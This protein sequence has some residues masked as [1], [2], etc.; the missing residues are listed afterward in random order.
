MGQGKM[1]PDKT[2]TIRLINK[3]L[4]E[5]LKKISK[6]TGIAI[7][8]HNTELTPYSKVSLEVENQPFLDVL[9]TLLDKRGFTWIPVNESAI[10]IKRSETTTRIIN[11]S[12]IDTTN[13]F[14]VYGKVTNQKGEPIP[15]AT[16]LIRGKNRGVTTASNGS[17]QINDIGPNTLLLISNIAFVSQEIRV[18]EKGNLGVISLLEYVGKLDET[19]VVA[20]GT[21]TKRMNLGNI[22]SVKEKEIS[23]SPIDNPLL[24]LQ[25]R[26]A[27]VF[28]EQST[29]LAGSGITVRVQGQNSL[30]RGN[31]PLYVID[32]IPYSSQLLPSLNSILG[33]NGNTSPVTMGSGSPLSFINPNDIESIDV[34]KDADATSIYGSRAA[35][36]AIL[37]T[38]KKGRAGETKVNLSLQQGIGMVSRYSD[39]LN[40]EEYLQMRREALKN[41]NATIQPTDYDLD[42]T[43]D[44]LRYTDWQ[45][46]LIGNLAKYQDLQ[47][48]ISGGNTQ[49]Q[50]LIGGGYRRQTTVFP[51]DFDDKKLSFHLN[52]SSVSRN[53]KL[54]V[55]VTASYMNDRNSL[56]NSDFT[57]SAL[58]LAPN[59]PSLYNSDGAVN[60][61][62]NQNNE[63]TF[64]ENPIPNLSLQKYKITSNNLISNLQTSYS[65]IKGLDIK[66]SVGYNSFISDE[67]RTTP[68]ISN[69]PEYLYIGSRLRRASYGDNQTRSW[70][71]EPQITY[72]KRVK[73]HK[74]DGVIGL[75]FNESVSNGVQISG[76][77]YNSDEI[78]QDVKSAAT[79]SVIS[80]S[81][82]NYKYSAGFGRLSYN[83]NGTYLVNINARR[84]GSSRFGAENKFSNFASIAGGW[85]F[86]NENFFKSF[87][88]ILTYGKLKFSYGS[89]GNDQIGDYNFLNLY[90]SVPSGLPYQGISGLQSTG[91]T[92]PYL[93]WESTRKKQYGIELGLINRRLYL[94]VIYFQ[95]KSSNQLLNYSLPIFAGFTD[96]QRNFPATIQNSG[97]EVTV[98]YSPIS[99]SKIS[100]SG[101]FNLTVPR[102]KLLRFRNLSSS[103]YA[104]SL[105][106]GQ[107]FTAIKVF[108]FAGVDSQTGL[109]QFF[110]ADN[111]VT[112]DPDP[113]KDN[114]TLIDLS[115][116]FYGGFSNSLQYRNIE[117]SFLLQFVKQVGKSP[118]LGLLPGIYGINQPSTVLNRWQKEGDKR[119]VQRFNSDYSVSQYWDY[120]NNSS[121]VSYSDA[122]YIRLKNVSISYSLPNKVVK[123]LHLNILKAFVNCQNLLTLTSYKGLD[124]ENKTS[125][126]LPPLRVVMAGLQLEL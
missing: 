120:A 9:H 69:R 58:Q 43:W 56:P 27:G 61:E 110:T 74:L 121:N 112:S 122:S 81:E 11:S 97:W 125:F 50:F 37:I 62:I 12:N 16:V 117:V 107:P 109:Y 47:A 88:S 33:G 42:G 100:W 48:S 45:K 31:D 126:S 94:D 116:K 76:N 2:V 66:A 8:Y 13:L 72:T 59:A 6:Q 111:H 29:G 75:T 21:T 105:T 5:V 99:T 123:R 49:N 79:V 35:A 44:T 18:K 55:T 89:T 54:K 39:L 70:I 57:S 26:V 80:T 34:L 71:F 92:N 106:V 30:T 87:S 38:T 65:L 67:I 124:P 53:E 83:Y 91:L 95:N 17:F 41:D 63:S 115:P 104:N 85:I 3:P 32:G 20:Y 93:Q 84:D 28:I 23:K 96:I 51:G 90:R 36:G 77:G 78:L 68:L 73:K 7:Y 103:S 114:T 10:T 1:L 14:T 46:E 24:A 25:G 108:N 15:G 102:N 22:G 82:F 119:S 40:T 19:V 113:I 101:N 86:S 98:N 64:S 118:N 52:I 4:T 60:W